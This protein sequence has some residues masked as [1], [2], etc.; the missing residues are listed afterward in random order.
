[1]I[2][3]EKFLYNDYDDLNANT[4]VIY[5]ENNNAIVIDPSVD[6]DSISGFLD[7]H[8][9]TPKAV[10]LTHGHFD[11]MRGVNILL[12]EFD[13]PLYIGFF[14]EDRLTDS[15]KNLSGLFSN[16]EVVISKKAITISDN[17]TISLLSEP[18]KV[19]ETPFH[20]KGSVCYYLKDSGL[21]FSGDTLFKG[22][23]GRDDLPG[24]EPSKKKS[25]LAKLMTLP[26]N[27]KVF[28]GHGGSSTIGDEKKY[29]PFVK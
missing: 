18:I 24:A 8:K 23:I 29:N 14:D 6:N 4:Y 3:V 27:T 7:R 15:Y 11:H 5:D 13:S 9:L 12:E 22:S 21:L 25:S 20:T 1:M 26:D 19:I 17:E 2:K 16:E 10:L 28:P